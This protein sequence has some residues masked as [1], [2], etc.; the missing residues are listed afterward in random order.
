[1]SITKEQWLSQT[2]QFDASG[3]DSALNHSLTLQYGTRKEMFK[4]RLLLGRI[5]EME[6]EDKYRDYI[7]F[8]KNEED[9]GKENNDS[10]WFIKL[11]DSFVYF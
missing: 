4:R 1:M 3:D 11:G 10:V 9:L 8:F 7:K 5:N 2:V 6:I